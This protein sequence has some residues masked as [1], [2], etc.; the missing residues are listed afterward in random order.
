MVTRWSRRSRL[1]KCRTNA[2][3][4]L[5]P[6]R[7]RSLLRAS[8]ICSRRNN[9]NLYKCIRSSP[10]SDKQRNLS[11]PSFSRSMSKPFST[12][13]HRRS[14]NQRSHHPRSPTRSGLSSCLHSQLTRVCLR[15]RAM[16]MQSPRKK[17]DFYG[18]SSGAATPPSPSTHR[19]HRH[20]LTADTSTLNNNRPS[21]TPA[22]PTAT[23]ATT[24]PDRPVSIPPLMA[25]S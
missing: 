21:S 17:R 12:H 16:L 10:R 9:S 6:S 14:L 25:S 3:N 13:R 8:T 18:K 5:A 7:R 1:S 4:R 20:S 2:I 24:L 15:S 23:P 19:S 11:H 22:C